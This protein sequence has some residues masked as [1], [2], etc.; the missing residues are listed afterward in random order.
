MVQVI[1]AQ[2]YQVHEKSLKIEEEECYVSKCYWVNVVLGL[3]FNDS[4][5]H[6]SPKSV[7]EPEPGTEQLSVRRSAFPRAEGRSQSTPHCN[8]SMLL[9][10]SLRLALYHKCVYFVLLCNHNSMSGTWQT[11]KIVCDETTWVNQANW[12]NIKAACRLQFQRRGNKTKLKRARLIS[13]RQKR[14]HEMWRANRKEK[15]TDQ[16]M[17]RLNSCKYL[18]C[19]L[20]HMCRAPRGWICCCWSNVNLRFLWWWFLENW[21]GGNKFKSLIRDRARKF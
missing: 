2:V 21:E 10:Q 16:L 12:L 20:S 15:L 14:I 11:F 18:V 3:V 9:L 4:R 17:E 1:K 7:C 8:V 19:C 13:G 5:F 6:T